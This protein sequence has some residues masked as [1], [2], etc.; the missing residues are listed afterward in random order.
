MK[1]HFKWLSICTMIPLMLLTACNTNNGDDNLTD[2]Q[3]VRY[4]PVNYKMQTDP[5]P[6]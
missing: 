1:K 4:D 6:I 2:T 5:V 3:N